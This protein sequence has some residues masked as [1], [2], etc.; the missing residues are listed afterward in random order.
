M[1]AQLVYISGAHALSFHLIIFIFFESTGLTR[2]SM[3]NPAL[4][5]LITCLKTGWE[6]PL[7]SS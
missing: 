3:T 7:F 1:F 5:I 4:V 6:M 2:S